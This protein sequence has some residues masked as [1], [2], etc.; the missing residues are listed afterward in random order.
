MVRSY[1]FLNI[2]DLSEG[3][4]C[5]KT[6]CC[7]FKIDITYKIQFRFPVQRKIQWKIDEFI[8]ETQ[9]TLRSKVYIGFVF[10]F[11]NIILFNKTHVSTT[12]IKPVYTRSTE[13]LVDL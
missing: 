9:H 13:W 1:Q 3:K 4:S 2:E 8:I 11:I 5:R 12:T 7:R 6:N 10:V